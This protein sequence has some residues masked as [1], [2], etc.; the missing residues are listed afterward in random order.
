MG[1]ILNMNLTNFLQGKKN[2]FNDALH[3][4]TTKEQ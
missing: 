1:V 2:D 3:K 4:T